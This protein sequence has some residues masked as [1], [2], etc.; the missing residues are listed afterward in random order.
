M[1]ARHGWCN[2]VEIYFLSYGLSSPLT[3]EERETIEDIKI[4]NNK[5]IFSS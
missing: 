2:N 1:H 4:I 5:S 3:H